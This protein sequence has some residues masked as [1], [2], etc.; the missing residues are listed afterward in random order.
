MTASTSLTAPS[1]GFFVKTDLFSEPRRHF[2]SSTEWVEWLNTSLAKPQLS[3]GAPVVIDLFAGCG[4]LALGFEVVGMETRGYE[5]KPEAVHT[6]NVNLENHCTEMMLSI[7][8]PEGPADMV[9]GGPPCQPFSQ[10]GYQRGMRDPRDGFPIFLDAVNRIRPKIAIIENVRGLLFRNKDY[11]RQAV[12]ELERFGYSVDVRLLQA[13]DYGVPQ[14]RERVI[15]V[16]SKVGWE[17]PEPIVY[18]PVTAGIAL[19]DLAMEIKEESRFLTESMDRYVASYEKASNCIRPRDLHLDRP[20]R[21][22]TC[23]NLGGA[24]ADMLRILLPD[25]RRRMLHVREAAR[26]QGFPDWFEFTGT[27]YEQTEQIGNAVP[28]L[29]GL[30]IARQAY[31]FLENTQMTSS[32]KTLKANPVMDNSPKAVKVEQAQTILREAGVS[33]RELTPRARERAA[34]C[35]LG[36]AQIRPEDDWSQ[37]KSLLEDASVSALRSRG[38]LSFR[39][40][41]YQEGLSSG[42]YDDVRRKDLVLLLNA[43]LVAGSAKDAA[44]DTNDGTRGYALTP[45]G[46]RLLRAFRTSEWESTLR[47][48]REMQGGILDRLARAREMQKVPVS[49]P[50]GAALMLS[51]GPHNEL[52]RAIIEEFLPRFARGAEVLYVGDTENKS[53][54]VDAEGLSSLGLPTPQR[55]DRLPDIVAYESERN[56]VF[57]VE[58]VHSSNP[59]DDDRHALLMKLTSGCTAGRVFVTAFLTRAD[60]RKWVQ[61][62]AWET[63]VWIAESPAHMIHF[64]GEKF[65]GPHSLSV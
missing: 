61:R 56:W 49:L 14:R 13:L 54:V 10:I 40:E 9:I 22:V 55:G 44:A 24:T 5:M 36:V 34:L 19:G 33:L 39:N 60:F 43:G 37:A 42:S 2:T 52:Q 64:D 65:L 62:I 30:A 11:L 38:I 18:Q 23:R 53:L 6:Y 35:L 57:L 27:P 15:V 58:A 4:G 1:Q 12:S 28:P 31:K 48:F 3:P 59:I 47:S 50:S 63:E 45:E 8:V 46:L 29:L 25:G 21:T 32:R 51:P 17:W 41:H 16:A 20:S 7:G 26:L